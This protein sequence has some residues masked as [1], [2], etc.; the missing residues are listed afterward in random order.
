MSSFTSFFRRVGTAFMLWLSFATAIVYAQNLSFH[1]DAPKGIDYDFLRQDIGDRNT[2]QLKITF[3][4]REDFHDVNNYAK[5]GLDLSADFQWSSNGSSSGI[6]YRSYNLYLN[7]GNDDEGPWWGNVNVTQFSVRD[8]QR[9]LGIS[10][11]HHIYYRIYSPHFNRNRIIVGE[12]TPSDEQRITIRHNEWAD[13]SHRVVFQ[14]VI[15]REGTTVDAL[16]APDLRVGACNGSGSYINMFNLKD[17][18]FAVYT[19]VGDT[20]RYFMAPKEENLA[21]HVDSLLVTD[22]TTCVTTD[23][24]KATLCYFYITD[25]KGNLCPT[26]GWLTS[27]YYPQKQVENM[28]SG[29]YGYGFFNFGGQFYLTAPDGTKAAYV[30][31]GTQT[32]QYSRPSVQT[33]DPDFLMPYNGENYYVISQVTIP[34]SSEPISLSLGKSN[35]MRVVTTLT[36]AAPYA[37]NLKLGAVSYASAPY[38]W[39]KDVRIHI[40]SREVSR[41]V[42]GNDLVITTLVDNNTSKPALKLSATYSAASDTVAAGINAEG[43]FSDEYYPPVKVNDEYRFTQNTFCLDSAKSHRLNFSTLHPVKFVLPCHL[44]QEGY[45]LRSDF[46]INF[47]TTHHMGCA[48]HLAI[49]TKSPY[50]KSLAIDTKSPVPYDT[51]T[52]LLPEDGEVYSRWY[53]Q[54][55]NV[56]PA[57]DHINLFKLEATGPFEQHLPDNQFAMLRVS[58]LGTDSLY[59]YNNVPEYKI[60]HFNERVSDEANNKQLYFARDVIPLHAGYNE[61]T[62]EYRQIKIEKDTFSVNYWVES[63]Q[64]YKDEEG[65]YY[66]SYTKFNAP[67]MYASL[68]KEDIST[69]DKA[70]NVSTGSSANIGVTRGRKVDP[71]YLIEVAPSK[72]DTVVSIYKNESILTKFTFNGLP[73]MPGFEWL[74]MCYNNQQIHVAPSRYFYSGRSSMHLLPGHYTVSG[75]ASEVKVDDETGEEIVIRTPINVAFDIPSSEVIEL[76]PS[77]TE[78]IDPVLTEG[79]GTPQEQVRYTIDGRRIT[80]PQRGVNLIKMSDGTVHKVLV[81]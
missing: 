22:T 56:K 50:A 45:Q 30:L 67:Y 54:Q 74:N 46:P 6:R 73:E 12:I 58:N 23:F 49:D 15:G 35:P 57:D 80:T 18:P 70:I 5:C 65:N 7:T 79:N 33:T 14:P 31:P 19:Q 21:L 64:F 9:V 25:T 39:G 71:V 24:R 78:A 81:K 72:A 77:V 51:I 44:M 69:S 40:D 55:G 28:I 63:R 43:S 36:D 10:S 41:Q 68:K 34:A 17:E 20:L 62:I 27:V 1:I 47:T 52:V 4:N 76:N 42:E 32:F 29:Y 75:I 59:V 38:A 16:L 13:Q 48:K 11:D 66:P 37:N 61:H 53:M 26:Q 8:L 60:F 3:S 2:G